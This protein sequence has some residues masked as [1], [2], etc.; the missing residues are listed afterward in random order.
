M[1]STYKQAEIAMTGDDFLQ[2][3]GKFVAFADESPGSA[4]LLI[5]SHDDIISTKKEGCIDRPF[6]LL[7]FPTQM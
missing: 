6:Y 4:R 7:D 5:L 3:A 1:L 2:A